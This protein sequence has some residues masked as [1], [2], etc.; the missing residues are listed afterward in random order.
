[1]QYLLVKDRGDAG[2]FG[3]NT[4]EGNNSHPVIYNTTLVGDPY[5]DYGVY[6]AFGMMMRDFTAGYIHNMIV[7]GI[8]GFGLRMDEETSWIV[9]DGN[10][11]INNGIFWNNN[12]VGAQFDPLVQD[13]VNTTWTNLEVIDHQLCNP[14]DYIMPNF[15]P[16]LGSPAIDGTVPVATPPSGISNRE[17]IG[18][19]VDGL[20][21]SPFVG[22][23]DG[24]CEPSENCIDY[25]SFFETTSFIGAVDPGN[26]W[27]YDEWTTFGNEKQ[28]VSD[29]N[30]SGTVTS[31][32]AQKTLRMASGQEPITACADA[33]NDGSVSVLDA[34][35]AL[36]FASGKDPLIIC[37]TE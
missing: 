17:Y 21:W 15:A 1:M 36:R 12:G 8:K 26:D 2:L 9:G 7:T 34:Q 19:T 30:Y 14:L 33:N 18:D 6:S 13:L 3:M 11:V 27:T 22:D 16:T 5:T 31:L 28:L 29:L 20:P 24:I 23:E 4:F 35:K 37:C 25:G 32:D 10:L